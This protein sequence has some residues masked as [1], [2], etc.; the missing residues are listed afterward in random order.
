VS[1]GKKDGEGGKITS[2]FLEVLYVE[3]KGKGKLAGER[4]DEGKE[5][6]TGG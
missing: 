2:R 6:G 5:K 4:K 3:E 1:V